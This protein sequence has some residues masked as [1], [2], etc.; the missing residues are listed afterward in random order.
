LEVN[1]VV[2]VKDAFIGFGLRHLSFFEPL[3]KYGI[4]YYLNGQLKRYK[5]QGK[6]SA[7]KTR[8]Q[9]LGKW[10]YKIVIDADLTSTQVAGILSELLTQSNGSGR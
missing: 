1:G 3:G 9:R 2:S 5:K 6:L 7:Y 4:S 10:H 8:I